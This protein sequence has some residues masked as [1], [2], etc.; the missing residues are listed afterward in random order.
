MVPATPEQVKM[1]VNCVNGMYPDY[2][3]IKLFGN[4][5]FENLKETE[6]ETIFYVVYPAYGLSELISEKK[7]LY[8]MGENI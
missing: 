4:E 7:P 1:L 8:Y 3:P 5:R 2:A 6:Y